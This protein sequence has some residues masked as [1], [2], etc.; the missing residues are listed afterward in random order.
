MWCYTGYTIEALLKRC[1]KEKNLKELLENVD[2]LVDS[3]F[4]LDLKSY[5]VPFRGSKNQRLIDSKKTIKEN[6]VCIYK[7]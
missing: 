3:P 6:K 4:I 2:V 5:N 1:K 7:D